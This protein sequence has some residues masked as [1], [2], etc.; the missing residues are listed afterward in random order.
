[1]LVALLALVL[2]ATPLADAAQ[3]AVRRALFADNAGKVNNI[4]A[5]KTPKAGQLLALNRSK[6]F[7]ASVIPPQA[8]GAKG[9]KGDPGPAGQNGTN[10]ASGTPGAPGAAIVARTRL[11]S[12][13]TVGQ[14][15]TNVPVPLTGA[16]WTQGATETDLVV[17]NVTVTMPATC[18]G[19]I[20]F[21]SVFLNVDGVFLTSANVPPGGG[22]QVTIGFGGGIA[23]GILETGTAASHTFTATANNGCT[24]AGE[25][26]TID[27]VT[28]DVVKTV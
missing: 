5:S 26:Y 15:Q 16:T 25:D 17:G 14:G 9:D 24:G 8:K 20:P 7:P 27:A 21:S 1:M 3:R 18:G 10:G 12:P 23:Y 2:A 6:R 11:A 28:L 13:T 19:F 4:R 22:G